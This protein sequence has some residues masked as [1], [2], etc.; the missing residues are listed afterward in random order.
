MKPTVTLCK[1][2]QLV[3]TEIVM[4]ECEQSFEEGREMCVKESVRLLLF[5]SGCIF[6]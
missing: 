4:P 5:S 3:E 6:S 1:T 2:V